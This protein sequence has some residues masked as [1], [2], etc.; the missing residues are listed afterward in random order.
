MYCLETVCVEQA[1]TKHACKHS[2]KHARPVGL[3]DIYCTDISPYGSLA[4]WLLFL[5]LFPQLAQAPDGK[6][7]PST[8]LMPLAA[9]IEHRTEIDHRGAARWR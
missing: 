8:A 2:T 5:P 7:P 9:E 4:H 3:P 1:G 6:R